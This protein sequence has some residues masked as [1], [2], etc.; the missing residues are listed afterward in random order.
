MKRNKTNSK[1]TISNFKTLIKKTILIEIFFITN[2]TLYYVFGLTQDTA[3]SCDRVI[4]VWDGAN[5]R[6]LRIRI[7]ARPFVSSLLHYTA[8]GD[9]KCEY[10]VP[11]GT[12]IALLGLLRSTL[13][14]APPT[15]T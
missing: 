5:G 6:D 11:C 1:T 14:I 8:W 7:F 12:N 13:F 9:C 4:T 2:F 15:L 10:P 3:D